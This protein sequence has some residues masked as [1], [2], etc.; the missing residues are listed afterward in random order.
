MSKFLHYDEVSANILLFLVA[1]YETTSTALAYSA[2]ILAKEPLI[3]EKLQYEIDHAP[4]NDNEYDRVHNMTYLD[5]FIR[6]VLRMY[7]IAPLAMTRECNT[8]TTV[9]GYTIEQGKG[10]IR[11]TCILLIDFSIYLKVASSNQIC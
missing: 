3:Q 1:G 10:S 7:P 4:E 6:E 5:W 9:C 11:R 8:K 2:F